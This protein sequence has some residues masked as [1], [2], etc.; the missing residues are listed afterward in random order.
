MNEKALD[1]YE[2]L[3]PFFNGI[4]SDLLF[5]IA[6]DTMFLSYAKH[7][8]AEQIVS[9]TAVAMFAGVILQLPL[10]WLIH[11]MGNNT[12]ILL[13]GFMLLASGLL[14]AFG[15]RYVTF[16]FAKVIHDLSLTL[17]GL[18]GIALKNNLDMRGRGDRYIILRSRGSTMYA[19]FTLVISFVA[20]P[21]FNISPYLPM[22]FCLFFCLVTL[23]MCTFMKDESEKSAPV[24][25][26]TEPKKKSGSKLSGKQLLIPG[27]AVLSYAVFFPILNSGQSEG[28]LFLQTQLD[29]F[30]G[31]SD[32]AQEKIV[33]LLSLVL[34]IS[35]I[36]RTAGN[37]LY[38][39]LAPKLGHRAGV[40]LPCMLSLCFVLILV[41]FFLPASFVVRFIVMSIGYVLILF[42]RDSAKNYL[43]SI[44]VEQLP[45]DLVKSAFVLMDLLRKIG[46]T[47]L[48]FSFTLLLQSHEMISI[49]WVFLGSSIIEIAVAVVLLLS[50][51]RQKRALEK[52]QDTL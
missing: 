50:I 37:L 39:K 29:T 5:W 11:K 34:I 45:G 20:G 42:P 21:L 46:R 40:I 22:G 23:F 33:L 16:V 38:E 13:G 8:S 3:Y 28:K 14:Y 44:L 31:D 51:L 26:Q 27:L 52:A 1:R 36:M 15:T 32:E 10:V 18:S 4:S 25:E 35:R 49:M 43:Q 9:L 47:L 48:N 12:S 24:K 2:K 19:I 7:L 17:I 41:G 6:I 30:L